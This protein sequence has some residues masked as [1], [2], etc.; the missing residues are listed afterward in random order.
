[1]LPAES[2]HWYV[3]LTA[4]AAASTA[5]LNSTSS[6]GRTLSGHE[7]L[8]SGHWRAGRAASPGGAVKSAG[9]ARAVNSKRRRMTV[10]SPTVRIKLPRPSARSA[11]RRPP[12]RRPLPPGGVFDDDYFGRVYGGRRPRGHAACQEW[13][14]LDRQVFAVAA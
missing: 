7:T 6:P 11:A 14:Q 10:S 13:P 5:A 3:N 9:S 2:S 12:A 4:A 8:I 1:M